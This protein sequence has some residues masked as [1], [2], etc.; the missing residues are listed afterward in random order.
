M[1]GLKSLILSILVGCGVIFSGGHDLW[2][3][4]LVYCATL[5]LFTWL[6]FDPQIYIDKRVV[7]VGTV[8]LSVAALSF[9]QS[10]QPSESLLEL[11]DW[12]TAFLLFLV[13]C[14]VFRSDKNVDI[15]VYVSIPIIWVELWAAIL[16]KA[17][18]ASF[19]QYAQLSGTLIN[20][21]IFACFLIFLVAGLSGKSIGAQDKIHRD[22]LVCVIRADRYGRPSDHDWK[23]V[24]NYT[25]DGRERILFKT[26]QQNAGGS[27]GRGVG[28]RHRHHFIDEISRN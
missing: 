14:H 24:G 27:C 6:L 11:E 23:L 22:L 5:A 4:T 25:H 1:N 15:L 13:S 18:L 9:W 8:V 3:A 7:I 20:P 26:F 12:I 28:D 21:N 17:E 2:A 16:Q 10:V 19:W